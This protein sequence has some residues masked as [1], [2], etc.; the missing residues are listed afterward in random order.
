MTA[1]TMLFSM[2]A[3]QAL[4]ILSLLFFSSPISIQAQNGP[5]RNEQVV[6]G[7][8]GH[9]L[10]A[11]SYSEPL[12]R[13]ISQLKALGLRAY[14]ININPT[15]M[16]TPEKMDR[17]TQL[18]DLAR[19]QDVRILPTIVIKADPSTIEDQ[20]Y[21]A[22]KS[23]TYQ[24]AKRFDKTLHVWELGNEYD[25]YCVE[26][27]ANGMDPASY[28]TEKYNIVRA[29][30]RGMSD[31]L[32]EGS[33]TALHIVETSQN[34]K[35]PD[36]GFLERLIR[37]GI[38]FDITSYHY[39]TQTG[40]FRIAENGENALEILHQEFHKPIWITEFDKAAHD[41]AGPNAVEQGEALETALSEIARDSRKYDIA[42]AYIYELLDQPELLS[43]K[44]AQAEFGILKAN[45]D[46]TAA[47]IAVKTF[48]LAYY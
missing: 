29:L 38:K 10:V 27:G 19:R 4:T 21:S 25:L 17:L 14:R 18:I 32:Q 12:E 1:K 43:V 15:N 5:E 40:Q 48:L 8:N 11:G 35:N 47:S 13:Q 22:A 36:S 41:G 16:M 34:G 42:E 33:P 39:Y 24:L 45:G 20:A 26:P 9:P 23:M 46:P 44:P 28:D 37:N 6:F 31:G 7:V 3:F 2:S 30:I